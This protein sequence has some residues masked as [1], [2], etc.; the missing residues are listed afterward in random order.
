[1]V[2]TPAKR[3][4]PRACCYTAT[5]PL[6]GIDSRTVHRQSALV[7]TRSFWLG[8]N[9][10]LFLPLFIFS[11]SIHRFMMENYRLVVYREVAPYQRSYCYARGRFFSTYPHYPLK[12]TTQIFQIHHSFFPF[13]SLCTPIQSF[14]QDVRSVPQ[15]SLLHKCSQP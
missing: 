1:V 3:K 11:V 9:G 10:V 4:F 15:A 12:C 8:I 7:S 13:G 5:T 2:R 6:F 14:P